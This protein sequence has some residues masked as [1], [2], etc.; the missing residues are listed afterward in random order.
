MTPN[1]IIY[2][3]DSASCRLR[4]IYT[5]R[6]A[7]PFISCDDTFEQLFRP[8]GCSSYDPPI[9]TDGMI[10]SP[11][12]GNVYRNYKFRNLTSA[13]LGIDYV[14]RSIKSCVGTPPVDAIDKKN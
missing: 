2:V 6:R 11:A 1:G 4:R 3:S 10:N 8:S 12:E 13:E 7:V 5:P 14:G 9:D